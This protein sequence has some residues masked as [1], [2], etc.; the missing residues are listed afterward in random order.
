MSQHMYVYWFI[1]NILDD[2]TTE[3]DTTR[4][5]KLLRPGGEDYSF[6]LACHVK[7]S[8]F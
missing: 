7:H 4:C 2:R 1:S 6:M 8:S 3:D 5:Q